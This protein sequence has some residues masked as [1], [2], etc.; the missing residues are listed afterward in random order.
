MYQQ[1]LSR[2]L[3]PQTGKVRAD[4]IAYRSNAEILRREIRSQ[5]RKYIVRSLGQA[6]AGG[7]LGAYLLFVISLAL[8]NYS[9]ADQVFLLPFSLAAGAVIGL[10]IGSLMLVLENLIEERLPTKWRVVVTSLIGIL[11][12]LGLASVDQPVESRLIGAVILPG[13]A[14][15]LPVGLLIRSKLPL[16]RS[17]VYGAHQTVVLEASEDEAADRVLA[18]FRFV[19]GL[20]LRLVSVF[21]I[22]SSTLVLA[23]FW[24]SQEA[25]ERLVTVYAFYYFICTAY[26]SFTVRHRE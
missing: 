8:Y 3:R 19:G 14:L 24:Y 17:L 15:G 11:L 12:V 25:D 16:W 18:A 22:L 20:A 21:G 23:A 10:V 2:E 1:S 4:M 13:T 26:I 6:M 5:S 7:A 9:S